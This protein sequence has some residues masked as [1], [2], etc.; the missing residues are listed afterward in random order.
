MNSITFLIKLNEFYIIDHFFKLHSF[1][2][3]RFR[4]I[5]AMVKLSAVFFHD[6]LL[7]AKGGGGGGGGVK[8]VQ[9]LQV[10][11]AYLASYN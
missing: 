4:V 9:Y 8:K 1:V 7:I 5:R 3:P 10:L 2:P 6:E 11:I